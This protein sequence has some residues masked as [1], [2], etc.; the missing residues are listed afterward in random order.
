MQG[1]AAYT[2]GFPI[3]EE[4]DAPGRTTLSAHPQLFSLGRPSMGS[5]TSVG[6]S[7]S[8]ATDVGRVRPD[9]QDAFFLSEE[10]GL[11]LVSDGMGGA[12]AGDLAS[13]IAIEQ[14]AVEI[15]GGGRQRWSPWDPDRVHSL[16]GDAIES[17]HM[18]IRRHGS[19]HPEDA[20]LGATV[21]VLLAD[22]EAGRYAVG[23]I[24]DSRAYLLRRGVFTQLTRDDTLLQEHVE[25]GRIP[26]RAASRHPFGHILS[27]VLG[28]SEGVSPQVLEGAL[29]AGDQFFLCSDGV[30]AVLNDREIGEMLVRGRIWPPD[31]VV[32]AFIEAVNERGGPD[33][34]T[35]VLLRR[36]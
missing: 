19:V 27:Q 28:M 24:G 9:N 17:A 16:L 5:L 15:G 10:L 21:T 33:N 20:G 11:A 13:R 23:H 1:V 34:A 12:P 32:R 4:I 18:E 3:P 29:E 6:F 22:A 7:G 31:T 35:A 30:T 14:V 26:A 25:D 2:W 36:G 8:G